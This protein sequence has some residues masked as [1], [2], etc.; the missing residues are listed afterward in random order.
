MLSYCLK[1]KKNTESINPKVS[2][3]TNGKTMIL[4]TCAICNSKKSKFI[5]SKELDSA[6]KEQ[7]A[8]GLLSNLRLKTPL[9]KIPLLRDILF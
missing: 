7:Q 8:K 5:R 4:S 2:K 6:V 3:T 1:C 9:N